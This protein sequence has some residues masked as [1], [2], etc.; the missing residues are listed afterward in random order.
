MMSFAACQNEE[1]IVDQNVTSTL[2]REQIEVSLDL[3]G[4]A[5]S[6]MINNNGDFSWESTD[7]LGACLVDVTTAGAV[8][9]DEHAGNNLFTY[10]D[11]KF[12]TAS[13]MSKGVYMFY[14]PYQKVN[15]TTRGGILVKNLPLVQK[16][17]PNGDEMMKNNFMVSPIVNIA[18]YE[19]SALELPMTMRS[20]YGYGYIEI[21]NG[22]KEDFEIQKIVIKREG[23]NNYFNVGGELAPATMKGN[24]NYLYANLVPADNKPIDITKV[25]ADID[26]EYTTYPGVTASWL[27]T[28]DDVTLVKSKTLSISALDG[29]KGVSVAAGS[30]IG[31][32]VLIPAGTY[33]NSSDAD[34][35]VTVYT[36]K[37]EANRSFAPAGDNLFIANSVKKTLPIEIERLSP[38]GSTI[39]ALDAN[40]LIASLQQ[41]KGVISKEVAV[42]LLNDM[43][44][45]SEVL[46][47]IP[48][49]VTVKFVTG[50]KVTIEGDADLNR[51]KFADSNCELTLKNGVFN[52]GSTFILGN[53]NQINLDGATLSFDKD[54][55]GG[56]SAKIN[57][58]KESV[59]N[60]NST[61][62]AY[63]DVDGGVVN[64]GNTS[65]AAAEPIE[66]YLQNVIDGIVN[67]NVPVK[68]HQVANAGGKALIGT[69]AVKKAAT[70]NVNAAVTGQVFKVGANGTVEY[71][72]TCGT[73]A[74][75]NGTINYN[76]GD[77]TVTT[78]NGT[79]NNNVA[80][81]SGI[82][83]VTTN[84]PGAKINTTKGSQ[85]NVE[86]NN[87]RIYF[88]PGSYVN[89]TNATGTQTTEDGHIVFTVSSEMTTSQLN[90]QFGKC[91][92]LLV[93]NA[94]LTVDTPITLQNLN[95]VTLE[96]AEIVLPKTYKNGNKDEELNQKMSNLALYVYGNS[97]ITGK[98]KATWNENSNDKIEVKANAYF[99]NEANLMGLNLIELQDGTVVD[100]VQKTTIVEN[101]GVISAKNITENTYTKW[102]GEAFIDSDPQ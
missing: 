84:N 34:F 92:A 69:D 15:T 33:S 74:E 46:K 64:F 23:D 75:N 95:A 37:G 101:Q 39:S 7:S 47:Q 13:T 60:Y 61:F 18:G 19:G 54:A 78:N 94:K 48:A 62:S 59:L 5:N 20:I 79:I 86:T 102:I 83:T 3:N 30:K 57:V 65:R 68:M 49:N 36:N 29:T 45:T 99:K 6:R 58:G 14:Y 4:T 25:F 38:S 16:W 52:L 55:K 8:A 41:F 67:V 22:T 43:T 81:V 17:D 1:L 51:I 53:Y 10:A 28:N 32:Y 77:L 100:K 9:N 63:I 93:K 26:K 2:E 42:T 40:D 24:N 90:E 27:D 31:T 21:T 82:L 91:T 70:I 89:M 76:G 44:L 88:T 72:V 66:A 50:T 85:S 56:A 96:D 12:T 80:A 97:S 73:I 11:G 87:G 35:T 98:G 71:N